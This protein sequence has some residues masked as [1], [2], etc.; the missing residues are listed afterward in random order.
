MRSVCLSPQNES[1]GEYCGKVVTADDAGG[2][3]CDSEDGLVANNTCTAT[4]APDADGN[5][6]KENR[7]D[8]SKMTCSSLRRRVFGTVDGSRV[9]TIRFD[10]SA[11]LAVA[12][13]ESP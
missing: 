11:K 12:L 10:D 3:R 8:E 5:E 2:S 1:R 7:G 6:E 13:A 4:D 9:D